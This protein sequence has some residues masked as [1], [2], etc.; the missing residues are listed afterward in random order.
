MSFLI[1]TLN[2]FCKPPKPGPRKVTEK[3]D[4]EEMP[5]EKEA[6]KAVWGG[7][8]GTNRHY[9]VPQNWFNF[10]GFS[11]DHFCVPVVCP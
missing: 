1:D 10:D 8:E 9:W 7:G 11:Y 6:E 2:Q 4:A 3:A 5:T